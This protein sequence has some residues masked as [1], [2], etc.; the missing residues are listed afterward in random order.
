MKVIRFTAI[1]NRRKAR[2]TQCRAGF[3]LN[4]LFVIFFCGAGLGC[5][6]LARLAGIERLFHQAVVLLQS[7]GNPN[8]GAGDKL[9]AVRTFHCIEV[10]NVNTSHLVTS[11]KARFYLPHKLFQFKT[12]TIFFKVDFKIFRYFHT[13]AFEHGFLNLFAAE[14]KAR[15]YAAV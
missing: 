12:V 15:A 10:L 5:N 1:E 13:L 8:Q 2:P 11:R 6:V 7:V 9:D 3:F 4:N 14:S